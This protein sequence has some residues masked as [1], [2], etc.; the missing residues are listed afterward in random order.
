MSFDPSPEIRSADSASI[1]AFGRWR[2]S[3]PTTIFDSKQ[4]FDNQPL[5]W[6]DQQESGGGTSSTYD[7]DTARTRLA[8]SDTTAGK[9]TR[10]TFM[11]FNY[12]SGKSQ[13]IIMTGILNGSSGA[14]ITTSMGLF[15]DNNGIFLIDDE[16]TVKIVRR[17]NVTGTPADNAVAQ[18][19]WNIDVF[20]GSGPSGKMLDFAK[21]LLLVIDLE[22]LGTGRV[23]IGFVIAGKI[24]YAH[25]FL[26]ANILTE[27][28]MSTPNLPLRYQIENDGT[29]GVAQMDHICCTVIS[30]G[31]IQDN[32]IL[33][34]KSTGGAHVDATNEN[35]LYA[36][37][38]MRLKATHVGATVDVV[39]VSI[40][41]HQGAKEF[42]WVLVFNGT[43][44]GG[45]TYG[46]ETNSAVQTF[47]GAT[48]NTVTGGTII[49]GG[50]TSS[51]RFGGTSGGGAVQNA[52]RLGVG[53]NGTSLD[54][55]VLA[56]RPVAGTSGLD[57]EGSITWRELS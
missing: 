7:Q 24:L 23:R 37:V 11:R 45:P 15:D 34:Y 3:S 57:F 13:Q 46:N 20:D 44:A 35:V 17:T 32:G 8:V 40:V 48:A 21:T 50:F 41:E 53:I 2:V 55:I 6:D 39:N 30:E 42:E 43:V 12:Q 18:A 1:D 10:Q 27:V 26:N 38:G 16:A 25:E 9:R 51:G 52:L 47:L 36:V 56:G 4:I 31:G 22:W 49:A 54:T 5:F 14:G 28:Y 33:R 29:G 19:S